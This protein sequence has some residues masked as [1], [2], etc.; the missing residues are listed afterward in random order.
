MLQLCYK[1]LL[2]L[3]YNK[4]YMLQLCY[5]LLLILHYNKCYM[6]Q[7]CYK[8][9]LILHYN[10][11]YMLQLC[12]KR[13]IFLLQVI[14]SDGDSLINF[15]EFTIMFEKIC[16][17]DITDKMRLLYKMHL[18][19]ALPLGELAEISKVDSEVY[20]VVESAGK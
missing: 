5:K 17:G 9:L 4:C 20:D 16:R 2:I 18:P 8:L 19:P 11:C 14:D 6:L 12:Y 10:K 3:H 1:L 15:K 7:L 13:F